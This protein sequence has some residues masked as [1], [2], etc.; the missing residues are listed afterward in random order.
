MPLWIALHLPLLPLEMFRPRWSADMPAAVY[1]HDRVLAVSR[2]A[3]AAGVR[4][5]MRR[6]SVQLLAPETIA[7]ERDAV[8][9]ASTLQDAALA[10]LQYSPLLCIAEEATILM[11]VA[12][13]LRLFGGIRNLCHRLRHTVSQLGLSVRLGCAPTARA[14]WLLANSQD[15]GH[16]TRALSMQTLERLVDRLPLHLLPEA[17]PQQEWLQGT[18]CRS[19]GQL[20]RLPRA[21]LQRRCGKPL[22]SALDFIYGRQPELFD[23]LA[24]PPTFEAR[25]ELPDHMERAGDLLLAAR[26][27][28]TAMM[29]WLAARQLAVSQITLTLEHERGRA[30]AA[31][32]Q[33]DILLAQPAWEEPHLLRLLKERLEQLNLS[34]PAV[35]VGLAAGKIEKRTAPSLTLFPEPGGSPQAHRQLIELLVARLGADHILQAAPCEDHR[36]EA[37]NR[38]I[39]VLQPK[40]PAFRIDLGGGAAKPQA[41]QF[42]LPR[43]VWLLPQ[44]I[45]LTVRDNR[46]FYGTVLTVAS[47]PERIEAGWWS[48][49]S[50]MRD[51]FIAEG[52]D[53]AW[54]W[55]YRERADRNATQNWYLHGLFA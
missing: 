37:A 55:I 10:L 20:R 33:V 26:H 28:L 43:P 48:G 29:G 41:P 18:G 47:P 42:H 38:W 49:D 39:P 3:S 50:V 31:P 22:L 45:M 32:T 13:S 11:E 23:W 46:P 4:P 25:V 1:D 24:A 9:E 27:L 2:L 54:Y 12:A 30:A 21:G 7:Y 6:A 8:R 51:Y 17:R 15:D 53:R 16:G 35:A 52:R 36:P 5:A 40:P 14:A 19:F 34:A 44:P